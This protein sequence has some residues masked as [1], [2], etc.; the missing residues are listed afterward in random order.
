MSSNKDNSNR[1]E[2]LNDVIII[3]LSNGDAA[4]VIH[5]LREHA[6]RCKEKGDNRGA[7]KYK[8]LTDKMVKDYENVKGTE[9]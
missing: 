4:Q 1:Q 9:E 8:E 2:F 3:R 5:A 7:E 6:R